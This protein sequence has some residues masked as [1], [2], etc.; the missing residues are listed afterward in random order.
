MNDKVE[1][2]ILKLYLS[3]NNLKLRLK[4]AKKIKILLKI[5][6]KKNLP[7]ADKYFN[8]ILNDFVS[9]LINIF[10]NEWSLRDIIYTALHKG[11]TLQ[12][13]KERETSRC[14]SDL[15]LLT[16]KTWFVIEFKLQIKIVIKNLL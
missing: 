4:L 12:K 2:S 11:I 16:K 9:I 10:N 5:L 7:V 3:A 6:I 1:D 14:F 13:I 8:T 15:E